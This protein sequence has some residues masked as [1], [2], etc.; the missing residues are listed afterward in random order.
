MILAHGTDRRQNLLPRRILEQVAFGSLTEAAE[1]VFI[2]V[3]RRHD[4]KPCLWVRREDLL[5]DR[6]T[7]APGHAQIEH[8][9]IGQMAR[10][11]RGRFLAIG[12]LGHD[13]HVRL[14]IHDGC[15]AIAHDRMIVRKDHPNLGC[16][17]AH[18]LYSFGRRTLTR[19]PAP[20]PLTIFHS[21]PM[22]W[23][24]SR[25]LVRPKPCWAWSSGW[26]CMPRPSSL[27]A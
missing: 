12:G 13:F 22:A 11:E 16:R 6:H 24:R 7:I 20:G 25:M 19:V 15:E 2:A 5:H 14:R 4:Q 27:T 10:I 3:I 21:P 26:R 1:D 18:R 23:A 8:H 9:H 17:S